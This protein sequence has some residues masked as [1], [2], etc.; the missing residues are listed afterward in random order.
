[1]DRRDRKPTYLRSAPAKRRRGAHSRSPAGRG[2]VRAHRPGPARRRGSSGP[3]LLGLFVILAVLIGA[4]GGIWV[5]TRPLSLTVAATPADA[6]IRFAE[7]SHEATGTL[8]A[9]EL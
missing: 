1:M 8:T 6:T 4:A 2:R 3:R 9:E 5:F 7:A